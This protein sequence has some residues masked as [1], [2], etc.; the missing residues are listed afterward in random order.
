MNKA[1]FS[2]RLKKENIRLLEILSVQSN[3]LAMN[4]IL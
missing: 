1:V 2:A 3:S 4:D